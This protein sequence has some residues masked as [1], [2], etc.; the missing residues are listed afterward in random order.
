MKQRLDQSGDFA[1]ELAVVIAQGDFDQEYLLLLDDELVG[2][3]SIDIIPPEDVYKRQGQSC[4]GTGRPPWCGTRPPAPPGQRG[5][6]G[7]AG[8]GRCVP[9]PGGPALWMQSNAHFLVWRQ[10]G[11]AQHCTAPHGFAASFYVAGISARYLAV[12]AAA[13]MMVL[14]TSKPNSLVSCAATHLR[15]WICCR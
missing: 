8:P 1:D 11:T 12:L 15:T 5:R 2:A 6:P 4:F 13:K 3:P 14:H 7:A 10:T 9:P